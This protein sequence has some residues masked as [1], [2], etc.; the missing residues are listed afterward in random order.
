MKNLFGGIYSYKKVLVTGHTGFKGSWLSLWLSL[1]GADVTGLSIEPDTNPNHI[2]LLNI[3]MNSIIGDIRNK[4]LVYDVIDNYKPDIVFHLA[5][6]PLV[7][8]SYK[9]PHETF[10]INIMG[11]VNIFEAC[12]AS[13]S[14]RAIINVTSD[15]CYDNKEYA[16][17]SSGYREEDPMGGF[18]PYSAS[19]GCVELITSSY[20]N[21]FF[22][23]SDYKKTHNILLASCRAGNIIGG[24]DWSEDRLV[25]DIIRSAAQNNP[26]NIRNPYAV[27]PWQHV[28]EPLSG[29]LLLGQKLLEEKPEFAE[30]WNF[31]PDQKSDITVKEVVKTAKLSW[32]QINYETTSDPDQPH[33]SGFLKLNCSKANSKLDWKGVWDVTTAIKKAIEW[34]RDFYNK[35]ILLT[36]NDLA[37]YIE[38]AE[39]KGLSWVSH[40]ISDKPPKNIPYARQIYSFVMRV[41]KKKIL[42]TGATGFIGSH[43]IGS[44]L[45]INKDIEII[46]SSR[47][48]DKAARCDWY[49]KIEYIP[50]NINRRS[51]N[52]YEYFGKPD[53]IIHLSWDGLPNYDELYHFERNLPDNYNFLKNLIQNGLSDLNIIGTCFEY[54]LQNGCLSE[55]ND[56]KPSTSYGI[57]KDTLRKF[58]NELKKKYPFKFKWIRPF[59]VYGRGQNENSLFGQLDKAILKK[60]KV[61]NMSSGEQLRDYLPVEKMSEYIAA[62]ALQD[63]IFGEINCCS[64]QPVSVRKLVEDYIKKT[65]TKIKLNLGFYSLPA[66]EP[67]AFWGDDSKLKE[68]ISK[69]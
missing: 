14:V 29:Y 3:K 4:K 38:D 55:K 44:L 18:D 53:G 64:G 46:A 66:Y 59:Y 40:K 63:K 5:A 39:N 24:G 13:E 20:R 23:L 34:Y 42:V 6:Q 31:G 10:E 33:E 17:S 7:R 43:I 47:N 61:F 8:K 11:T 9:M 35:E 22:N 27:R 16:Y 21:S 68:I 45:N 48:K 56:A 41:K 28:M 25:P 65:N 51:S 60:D 30:A 54:G 37:Y 32:E 1:L 52:L 19:K 69:N 49:N 57:A 26:I 2:S 12:R 50:L 36:E 62:I 67:L 15:K 58:L